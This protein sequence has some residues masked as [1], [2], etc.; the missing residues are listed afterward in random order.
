MFKSVSGAVDGSSIEV[1]FGT[2]PRSNRNTFLAIT[3]EADVDGGFQI[4]TGDINPANGSAYPE[5]SPV[6]GLDRTTWHYLTMTQYSADGTGNDY[7]TVSVGGG[8]LLVSPN[9]GQAKFNTFESLL[10]F[11]GGPYATVD[12][13]FFRSGKAASVFGAFVDAS[14]Q[15][16]YFDDLS[17]SAFNQ[18]NVNSILASYTTNFKGVPEPSSY[19]LIGIVIAA[20]LLRRR[21][22]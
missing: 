11:H 5:F 12:N 7:F 13:V 22:P 6:I 9:S 20:M 3:N 21:K 16:I 17:Y 15:G 14:V 10:Q 4:R 19:A 18:A 8:A 2:T 1:D